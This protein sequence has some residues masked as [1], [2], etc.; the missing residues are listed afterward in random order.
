MHSPESQTYIS[1]SRNIPIEELS[2]TT[3]L[4]SLPQKP[5]KEF[6]STLQIKN[7]QPYINT[8]KN[9]NIHQKNIYSKSGLPNIENTCY[10]N[11]LIQ[12]FASATEFVEYI[13]YFENWAKL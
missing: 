3:R 4:R 13:N 1:D 7:E 2:P 5:L 12:I 8:Q 11:S 9:Y 10:M 6:P